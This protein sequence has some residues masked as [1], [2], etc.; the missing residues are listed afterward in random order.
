[1]TLTRLGPS[2]FYLSAP[3]TASRSL[4]R[5]RPGPQLMPGR[6][7]ATGVYRRIPIGQ[8]TSARPG[9][10]TGPPLY[11]SR[12]MRLPTQAFTLA[13]LTFLS[14]RSA[15]VAQDDRPQPGHWSCYTE[16]G[17][18]TVYTT[19]VWEASALL[20]EV[21]NAFAQFLLTRYGYQGQVFCGRANL[22]GATVAKLVELMRAR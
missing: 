16:Y 11:Q 6:W 4:A 5:A 8:Q 13:A 12:P 14:A 21:N 22:G 19:R 1:M 18:G 20:G 10:A 15:L 7:A 17:Q 9:G 2:V 3:P